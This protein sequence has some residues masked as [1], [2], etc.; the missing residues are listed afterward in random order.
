MHIDLTN[1]SL[2]KEEVIFIG[3]AI[4]KSATLLGIHL[5]CNGLDYY[6]RIFFRTRVLGKVNYHFRN[7]AQE[8]LAGRGKREMKEI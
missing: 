1:T 3:M 2:Q 6:D 4:R 7:L 5:S 8:K